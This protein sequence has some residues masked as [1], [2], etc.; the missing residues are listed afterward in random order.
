VRISEKTLEQFVD[1]LA[2]KAPT[3]GGGSAAAVA[4]AL[5]A[6]LV[7]MVCNLT[8]GKKGYDSV[9]ESMSNLLRRSGTLRKE[10]MRLLEEDVTAFGAYSEAMRMPK[11]TDAER[12]NRT[13]A[14]QAALKE[15]TRVPLRIARVAAK[16]I[17]LCRP[18]AEDGNR[19]VISD[20]GVAVV[21][22]EAAIRCAALNVLINLGAQRDDSF[23]AASRAELDSIV[24]G[25]AGLCADTYRFVTERL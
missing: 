10:S 9:Q 11:G 13:A 3:P 15:A 21:L 2:S 19:R 23:V 6:S 18:C 16:V 22:A 7:E 4:A 20:A 17:D 14:T 24:N 8:I 25:T 12:E 1:E 5:A